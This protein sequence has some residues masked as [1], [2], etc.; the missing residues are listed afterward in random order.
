MATRVGTFFSKLFSNY[1]TG[2]AAQ[3]NAND[4]NRAYV[5]PIRRETIICPETP[6][7]LV[8]VNYRLPIAIQRLENFHTPAEA[9]QP[10]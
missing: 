3:H 6:V 4:G 7:I 5:T 8:N 10:F 2:E 1:R 9:R